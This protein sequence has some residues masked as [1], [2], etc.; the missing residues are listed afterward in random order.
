[1]QWYLSSLYFWFLLGPVITF[2]WLRRR[3]RLCALQPDDEE[4][5]RNVDERGLL[6]E[7]QESVDNYDQETEHYQTGGDEQRLFVVM[8]TR[9]RTSTR[10]ISF[11]KHF[12]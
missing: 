4:S 10:V 2:E 5:V 12:W 9:Q 3:K 7:A 11:Q 1:M 8:R 6:S